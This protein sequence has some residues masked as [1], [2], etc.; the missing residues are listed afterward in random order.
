MEIHFS[1]AG[2]EGQVDGHHP[3]WTEPLPLER[4]PVSADQAPSAA[5]SHGAYFLAVQTY[6]QNEGALHL[7]AACDRSSAASPSCQTPDR[8]DVILEKHGAFYHPSRILVPSLD[9]PRS[10]VLNVALTPV[11]VEWME[12]EIRS[13]GALSARLPAASIPR[14]CGRG[15]V[16]DENGVRF[17]MFLAEW[18]EDFHEFHLSLDPRDGTQK[19]IVWDQGQGPFF[20]A[21]ERIQEVY[22]Q[23]AY[24]LTRAYDPETTR[25]IYP[26][27]HA[28]GDFVL[29]YR[30]SRVDVK[31]ISVRQYAPTLAMATH[32]NLDDD[33]RRMAAMVFFANLTLRNRIDRRDGTGVL[34]WAD[35]ATV[36][37][38]VTGFKHGWALGSGDDLD[39]MLACYDEED[40]RALLTVVGPQYRLMPAEKELLE[41]HIASHAGLIVDAI[42]QEFPTDPT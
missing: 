2:R 19:I 40:W 34:A 8:I 23:T 3:A 16:E 28:A 14:V 21:P 37:A 24:L 13:L 39:D 17:E 30:E 27:H 41:R 1:I 7:A 42:R 38:T 18:F 25:Q 29:R 31:L 5:V 26:W 4:Q 20:L 11:G 22:Q 36:R 32:R 9:T 33:A 15:H 10:F 35:D 12:N 6:L